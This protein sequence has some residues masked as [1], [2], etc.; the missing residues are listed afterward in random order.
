MNWR[1]LF[2]PAF[3]VSIALLGGAAAGLNAAI[4]YMGI[5][6]QKLPIEAAGD[7]KF[8]TLPTSVPGW[9]RFGSD[10]PPLTSEVLEELGTANYISRHYIETDPTEG[11]EAL[12]FE[13]H[14]AYYTGMID[15]VPHVPERCFV[16]GGLSID[17]G[18]V[19]VPVPLDLERFPID[20]NLDPEI[21]KG[22]VRRG[23]TS[24]D[25]DAPGVSVHMP[26]ELDKLTMLVTPFIDGQGNRIHAGYFFLANG[27][28]VA[29]ANDVRLLAFRKSDT[30]AYYAKVQFMSRNA[31]SPEALAEAAASFLNEMLPE[32]MRRVP[33]WV[34]VMDGRYPPDAATAPG[35][36]AHRGG[37]AEKNKSSL[38]AAGPD[39]PAGA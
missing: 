12:V 33:D 31:E 13:L 17:G 5:Q 15:T 7:L 11:R 30:Y 16:G 32:I 37:E 22:E 19:A 35:D 39:G 34:D 25:S 26:R 36:V 24:L 8:H 20:P 10:P 2:H 38:A 21:Y 27:G 14:C 18:S 3:I 9:T 4:N 29:S 1:A 23:R 28:T 6:L